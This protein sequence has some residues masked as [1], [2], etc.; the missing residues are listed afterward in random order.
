MR[1]GAQPYARFV[2]QRYMTNPYLLDGL[3]FDLRVYV[4]ITSVTPLRAYVMGEGLARCVCVCV[5]VRARARARVVFRGRG[6]TRQ[7]KVC[8]CVCARV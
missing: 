5:C 8:V 4:L 6:S 3:K 2:V 1:L 7:L